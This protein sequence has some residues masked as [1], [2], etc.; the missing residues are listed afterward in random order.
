[1]VLLLCSGLPD[2]LV[3]VPLHG[4]NPEEALLLVQ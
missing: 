3:D 4:T 1:M 2:I